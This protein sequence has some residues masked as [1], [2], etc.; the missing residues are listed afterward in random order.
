MTWWTAAI[1]LVASAA[2]SWSFVASRKFR[3][4]FGVVAFLVAAG[5]GSYNLDRPDSTFL[6]V[7]ANIGVVA[8]GMAIGSAVYRYL[9]RPSR[10]VAVE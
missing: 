5:A 3:V 10:R 4:V 1:I 9:G 6:D 2:L 8:V 7:L